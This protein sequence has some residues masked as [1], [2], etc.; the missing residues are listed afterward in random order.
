LTTIDDQIKGI[1]DL[2][3][4]LPTNTQNVIR[5]HISEIE[6][7]ITDAQVCAKHQTEVA[8]DV[9]MLSKLDS[10]K[11]EIVAEPYD[12][13]QEIRVVCRMITT[14]LAK[15]NL[16]LELALQPTPRIVK[17]DS[18]RLRQVLVNLLSNSIKFTERGVISI[19]YRAIPEEDRL[20]FSVNDTGIGM[21]EE[22]QLN[23]F[24]PFTQANRSISSQYGGTGLGL[25]ISRQLVDLM[26]G[27][28]TVVSKKGAGTM[29]NFTVQYLPLMNDELE[30]FQRD[31][32]EK[33]QITPTVAMSPR[34]EKILIV[35]DN[36]INR[37][38]LVNALKKYGYICET[39][40]DGSK[41][42]EMIEHTPFGKF[43]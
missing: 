31:T 14:Q 8:N 13:H 20:H 10:R 36:V 33:T 6:K 3:P 37:K 22:E 35:D 32:L 34:F 1:T 38:V 26:G 25:S 11:M 19:T 5:R 4:S 21:T 17:G 23:L 29:I 9:L 39:A 30:R 18:F 40:V 28:I 27:T 7:A 2:L 12:V 16:S 43:Y 42:I 24:Q 41:A 15:R